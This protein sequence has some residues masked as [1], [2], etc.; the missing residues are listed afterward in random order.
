[1]NPFP[2]EAG[3]KEMVAD[4]DEDEIVNPS[5]YHGPPPLCP[6]NSGRTPLAGKF[7]KF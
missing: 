5:L 2:W 3:E 1:M 4:W 6:E 7:C